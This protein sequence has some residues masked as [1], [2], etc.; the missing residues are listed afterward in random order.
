[1]RACKTTPSL[2]PALHMQ[3]HVCALLHSSMPTHL[4]TY[5]QMHPLPPSSLTPSPDSPLC[6]GLLGPSSL[7]QVLDPLPQLEPLH[8]PTCCS[9]D[10]LFLL[11]FPSGCQGKRGLHGDGSDLSMEPQKKSVPQAGGEEEEESGW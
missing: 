10:S 7:F 9:R 11:S 5:T 4:C 8:I 1:M 2:P 6:P 3:S